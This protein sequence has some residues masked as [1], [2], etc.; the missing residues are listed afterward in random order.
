MQFRSL[1]N[2][3]FGKE[4]E[5]KDVTALKLLNGYTNAYTPFSGNAYDDA[6]VR[7]CIDTIAR[8]FGKMR[9]KHVIKDNGKIIK[10]V[11]DRLNYLLGSY[12]NELMTASEFLEKV[13]NI[14][15]IIMRLFI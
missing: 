5:Y 12:P 13:P 1:F 9:P 7:D 4:K 11:D 15:H 6:T 10:T 14:T 3:V 2:K 8:H